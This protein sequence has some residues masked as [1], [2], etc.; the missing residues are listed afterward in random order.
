[1]GVANLEAGFLGWAAG[2]S[3]FPSM[4]STLI[5]AASRSIPQIFAS[6]QNITGGCF[7]SSRE[8]W[9]F[10]P[11]QNLSAFNK[12]QLL[13]SQLLIIFPWIESRP[14]QHTVVQ[15]ACKFLM[16]ERGFP[17]CGPSSGRAS[18]ERRSSRNFSQ[19]Y[20]LHASNGLPRPW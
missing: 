16:P 5:A 9:S 8:A 1:M 4:T 15:I 11:L 19:F 13:G 17:E 3:I 10:G 14:A 7:K 18:K 2:H 6:I 12:G 20:T